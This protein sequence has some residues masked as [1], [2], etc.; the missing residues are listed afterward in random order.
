[1]SCFLVD[2]GRLRTFA[3]LL[4]P[5]APSN[6]YQQRSLPKKTMTKISSSVPTSVFN[7]AI[8]TVDP[9]EYT[10]STS[11]SAMSQARYVI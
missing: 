4:L 6:R 3:H 5:N 9:A 2:K 7:V 1:M 10:A 8:E 11:N